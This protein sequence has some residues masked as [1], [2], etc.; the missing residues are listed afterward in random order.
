MILKDYGD[1]YFSQFCSA[2]QQTDFNAGSTKGNC[3]RKAT[4]SSPNNSYVELLNSLTL[5]VSHT[6]HSINTEF[7]SPS[8]D[9]VYEWSQYREKGRVKKSETENDARKLVFIVNSP[10]C[11]YHLLWSCNERC[12]VLSARRPVGELGNLVNSMSPIEIA[13][14]SGNS[15][16]RWSKILFPFFIAC[17]D[18]SWSLEVVSLISLRTTLRP[19]RKECWFCAPRWFR[20]RQWVCWLFNGHWLWRESDCRLDPKMDQVYPKDSFRRC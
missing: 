17:F 16:N 4:D 7:Y 14:S 13:D 1:A 3:S 19:G 20:A 2:F 8:C 10:N 15:M 18:A 6:A 11:I 12:R 5:Q 9:V